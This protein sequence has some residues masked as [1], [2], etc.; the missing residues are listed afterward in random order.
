MV[1][2][3]F[4]TY[5]EKEGGRICVPLQVVRLVRSVFTRIGL[6]DYL[7]SFKGKGVPLG[8]VVEVMYIYNLCTDAS[9]NRWGELAN[10]DDLTKDF[11][12]YGYTI[13]RKTMNR[14]LEYL[15]NYFEEITALIWRA[16]RTMYPNIRTHCYVDGSFI[17]RYGLK[18]ENV[19]VDEGAGTLQTQD[20]FMVAQIIGIP[21]PMMTELYPGNLNDPPQYDDFLSQL[22]FMLDLGSMIVMD[23]GGSSKTTRESI[24]ERG[25]HYLTRMKTNSS[26]RNH[27]RDHRDYTLHVGFGTACI[28]QTFRSSL[29]TTYLFFSVDSYVSQALRIE[30]TI[31][32]L[33]EKQKQAQKIIETGDG[34][35]LIHI[36]G[37]PFITVE[38]VDLNLKLV[39]DPWEE[40]DVEKAI[41]TSM[42]P[43]KGW[44]KLECSLPLDPRVVLVL[45]RHR[46]D[47]EHLISALKT[48]IK[49]K[50]L[51]VW[52]PESTRGSLLFATICEL[53]VSLL[54]TDM[55]H[56]MVE[57]TID[58]KSTLVGKKPSSKSLLDRLV[59]WNYAVGRGQWMDF[60]TE[61]LTSFEDKSRVLKVIDRYIEECRLELVEPGSEYIKPPVQWKRDTKNFQDLAMSI[62]QEISDTIFPSHIPSS[63]YWIEGMKVLNIDDIEGDEGLEQSNGTTGLRGNQPY[64]P[65]KPKKVSKRKPKIRATVQ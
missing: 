14:A 17:K 20:Q 52:V 31:R 53:I 57:K 63:R 26:D 36:N 27:I 34:S 42:A 28:M 6:R 35:K 16:V 43:D 54:I 62:G 55:E 59:S 50:P 24:V 37:N 15:D 4:K 61:D 9:M 22:M 7:N 64:Y 5:E 1:Q 23:N 29:R 58:G 12:C 51:R 56:E 32:N 65:P 25:N 46:V 8:T 18:G 13:S 30:K 40:I 11:I 49:M 41:E 10:K 48:A 3:H 38:S 60:T 2:T 45:Y 19:A 39:R 21:I 33:V 44:F 47:V